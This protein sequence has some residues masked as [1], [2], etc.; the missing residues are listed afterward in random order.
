MISKATVKQM[1]R[2]TDD[3]ISIVPYLVKTA[4][5]PQLNNGQSSNNTTAWVAASKAVA[6]FSNNAAVERCIRRRLAEYCAHAFGDRFSRVMF[7]AP[8]WMIRFGVGIL[9]SYSDVNGNLGHESADSVS[10]T[11]KGVLFS[12]F[13]LIKKDL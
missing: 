4:P 11:A 10:Y 8:P 1:Q 12:I 6:P 7:P 13:I 5:F 3:S 2:P 9:E